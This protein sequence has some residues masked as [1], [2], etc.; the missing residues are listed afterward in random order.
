MDS[1]RISRLLEDVSTPETS[2][3]EDPYH[4]DEGEYGSDEDYRPSAQSESSEDEIGFNRISARHVSYSSASNDSTAPVSPSLLTQE[5]ITAVNTVLQSPE[6]EHPRAQTA[7]DNLLPNKMDIFLQPLEVEQPSAQ[8]VSDNLLPNDMDIFLLSPEVEQPAAQI[9]TNSA[10]LQ[11]DEG[12]SKTTISIA[13]FHFDEFSTGPK[14]DVNLIHTPLD[15]FKLVFPDRLMDNMIDC[16]NKYGEKLTSQD[17]PRT[18]NS[19][20]YKFRPVDKQEMLSVL[21]LCLLQGQLKFPVRRYFFSNDPLYYHPFFQYITSGRRFE[22]II[23]C[24]C[25]A[26]DQAKGEHKILD[27][28]KALNNNFQRIYGPSKELSID[29]SLILFRGRIY[30]RQYIKSKK[31][32]YGIKFY[33]LTTADG[34]VLDMMM[35]RG[36]DKSET[37]K[38]TQNIVLK[39][40]EPY[41]FKGHHVFMDNFYNSVELSHKL[42]SLRT[43]SCGTLRKNRKGNPKALTSLKLKKGDYYWFR[44]GQIYVSMWRDKRPVFTISTR[45]HPKLIQVSNRYGKVATKPAE[46]AAYNCF[47]GGVDRVDQMTSYYSSPRKSLRWYKRVTFHCL[48]VAVWNAY[49]LYKKYVKKNDRYKSIEFRDQLIKEMCQVSDNV[50]GPDVVR[51]DSV[52]SSRRFRQ[53]VIEEC[54][55]AAMKGHWPVV[56]P[57]TTNSDGSKRKFKYLNCKLCTKVNK[58][59]ETKYICKGCV[60]RTPLCPECFEDWHILHACNQ[61]ED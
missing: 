14:F 11:N 47:M 15:M 51:K 55:L 21:G 49:Y 45:D 5:D 18:R 43:H 52:Y 46:V 23:R 6:V 16:T 32:R 42:L 38:K 48:D 54:S 3:I 27:F 30:F 57:V 9:V 44:K 4:D 10:Q 22:Q 20:H 29:E 28:I 19:R 34:Y 35:Y 31:A 41:L 37:G 53:N 58:R 17:G 24:L 39:L 7:G 13:D 26:D 61:Q 1:D 25:V 50:K 12:W 2:D 33:V 60:K 56:M 40:L 8:T 36:K 59:K